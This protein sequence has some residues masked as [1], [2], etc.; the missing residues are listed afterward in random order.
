MKYNIIIFT[1]I[2]LNENKI[3]ELEKITAPANIT[4]VADTPLLYQEINCI[5]KPQLDY[6]L[7]HYKIQN[8]L[9]IKW[10]SD[11][12]ENS[13]IKNTLMYNRQ[14]EFRSKYIWHQSV[15]EPY[16]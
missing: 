2:P 8:L 13:N 6:L 10:E 7:K 5:T 4:I 1:I 3:K 11:C 15:L 16:K 12:T 14:T 9:Q